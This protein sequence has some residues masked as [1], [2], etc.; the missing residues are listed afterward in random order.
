MSI[1]DARRAHVL[2]LLRAH[3]PSD[4]QE[5]GF[6]ERFFAL[7][8]GPGDPFA[9]DH[10]Q[11]GHLT[12]S[13]FVLSPGRQELL[14]ILH[15]KLHRWLQPGGHVEP[16]DRDVQAAARREVLEEVG[17]EATVLPGLVDV[18]I[19]LIPARKGE[20]TH[21]HFDLRFLMI[22]P[23]RAFKAGS[24]AAEARWVPLTAV[25]EEQSDASVMRAVRRILREAR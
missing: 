16:D 2:A 4:A 24:D 8:D 5:Q 21:A 11:P 14:L 13:A 20:P 25:E 23:D 15:K 19:H 1:A 9:R 10:F 3:E 12:A 17:I 18:D 7:L 22:A 6:I